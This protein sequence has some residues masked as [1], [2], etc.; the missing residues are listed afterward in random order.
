MKVVATTPV[1]TP[2]ITATT[3]PDFSLTV[4]SASA[5]YG[6]FADFTYVD[7]NGVTTSCGAFTYSVTLALGNATN[8]LSTCTV[9]QDTKNFQVQSLDL[10]Q[11]GTFIATFTGELISDPSQRASTTFT[12][13]VLN[14][15]PC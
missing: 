3:V 8:L 10:N 9:N 7:S 1:L 5:A 11:V 2:T 14:S 13:T 15:N 6:S 12:I 4:L